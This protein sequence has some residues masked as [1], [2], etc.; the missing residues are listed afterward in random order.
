[1]FLSDSLEQIMAQ[2]I[3]LSEKAKQILKELVSRIPNPSTCSVE[4]W[5]DV[6]KCTDN[7]YRHFCKQHEEFDVDAFRNFVL[8]EKEDDTEEQKQLLRKF[9]KFLGW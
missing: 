7:S 9:R 6:L 2:D 8:H 4:L 3:T 1:M 5:I